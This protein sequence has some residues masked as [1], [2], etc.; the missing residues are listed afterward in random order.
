MRAT[1]V[2]IVPSFL[3]LIRNGLIP[4]YCF[5]VSRMYVGAPLL[6]AEGKLEWKLTEVVLATYHAEA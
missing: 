4:W 5:G 2:V 1:A 3:T 6:D